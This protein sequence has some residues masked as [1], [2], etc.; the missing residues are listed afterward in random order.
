MMNL[1]KR[2]QP[3]VSE[4]VQEYLEILWI[5]E[6]AGKSIAKVGWLAEHLGVKPPSV[7]EMYKKLEERGFVKYYPYRGVKFVDKGREI[8]KHVVRNHRLVEL[9]MKQTLNIDVDEGVACGV[10]HHM[11]E[12]FTAALC[13]LLGHP[14][15]C[16]HGNLIPMGSC[17]NGSGGF[18]KDTNL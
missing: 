11:T 10:E 7:V 1:T 8:A 18:I 14:R 4:N 15:R 9:L 13:S 2:S 3:S 16:P 5:S 12:E 6:E 17:C